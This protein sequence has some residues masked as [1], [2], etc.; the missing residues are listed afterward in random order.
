VRQHAIAV[1]HKAGVGGRAE[2][3]AY[4]LDDLM[5]PVGATALTPDPGNSAAIEVAAE[6]PK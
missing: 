2:L 4:F 5:P 1:Y 3:A 6:A